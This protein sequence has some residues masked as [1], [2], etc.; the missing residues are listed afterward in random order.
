MCRPRFGPGRLLDAGSE[1]GG[2]W[3]SA[4]GWREAMTQSARLGGYFATRR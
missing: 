1:Y 4:S 2:G 3:L